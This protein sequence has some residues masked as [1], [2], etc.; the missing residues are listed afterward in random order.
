[1][2]RV[3]FVIGLIIGTTTLGWAPAAFG[4]AYS[5]G[6]YGTCTYNT[7]G[8]TLSSSGTVAINATPTSGTVCTVQS[9]SVSA[10]TG[11][12]TGYVI[13]MTDGDT[14]NSLVSG[15]NSVAAVSGTPASP[16]ALSAN[17]W[18]YRIDSIG[19]FGAGPTSSVS[20]GSIPSGAFSA[21]PLSSGTAATVR[22]TTSADGS[23]VNT[24]VWYG[25]CVN[26]SQPS[27]TYSDSITYTAVVNS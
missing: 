16:V 26:A 20:N 1:M 4:I 10:T 19:G 9:D 24:P 2:K 15:G 8:I 21:V 13:S 22:S 12:T 14:N 6:S 17:K 18:G 5:H 25:L 11:A 3:L 27:G 7:C 23:T